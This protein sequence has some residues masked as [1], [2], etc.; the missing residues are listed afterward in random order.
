[1]FNLS[2]TIWNEIGQQPEMRSFHMKKMFMASD[3]DCDR[4]LGETIDCMRR[5]GIKYK[6]ILAYLKVAPLL[7]E[8]QAIQSWVKSSGD[9]EL[10]ASL[11]E[12]ATVADA[13]A[14]MDREFMLS[15]ADQARLTELLT[16][17]CECCRA[18]W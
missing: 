14:L 13:V 5:L 10:Q 15:E 4:I 11:P 9:P 18:G 12:I 2:Q 3:E 6:V 1:M 16:D 8:G 17:S 7:H